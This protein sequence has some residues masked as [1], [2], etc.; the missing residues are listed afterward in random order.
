MDFHS[1]IP[2]LMDEGIIVVD[3]KGYIKVYNKMA[4]DIFGINPDEGT[5][6]TEGMIEDGDIVIIADNMLGADDGGMEP[7]DLRLIGIDPQGIKKGNAVVAIG[8]KGDI[9]GG[10]ISKYLPKGQGTDLYLEKT[11]LN[12]QLQT[13]I[14]VN[15]KRLR[16]KVNQNIYD[17]E[18]FWGA[19]HMVILDGNTMAVKFYQCKGYTARREPMKHI[20]LG[21]T[22]KGKGR[23][24]RA[25][26]TLDKHILELHPDSEVIRKL[27][28]VACGGS[29]GIKGMESL[30]NGVPVRCSVKAFD[31]DG[32][33]IGAMLE[34][35][36]ISEL[37]AILV[38]KERTLEHLK[39]LEDRLETEQ[40]EKQ[41]FSS[42]I[43]ESPAIKD[44]I[45]A[46]KK[47]AQTDSTVLLL[48]E[49]GTG[50]NLFAEAIHQASKRRNGPLVYINCASIP[51]TLL[52]SELFGHEKG[53]FTGAISKKLGKFELAHN[54]TIFLDEINEI[55]LSLQAKLLHVIQSRTFTRV[56]GIEP[57]SVNIRI[58]ATSNKDLERLVVEGL[59]RGDLFYR[60]NVISIY[61]PPLRE[62]K[63][64]LS[65]LIGY[66]LRCLE[67]KTGNGSKKIS[68]EVYKIFFDY[69]WPGNIRELEN[70][71]ER[72]KVM[73]G[74]GILP[75]HLPK[76]MLKNLEQYSPKNLVDI[77]NIGPIKTIVEEVE[78]KAIEKALCVSGGN[79]KKAMRLL[80]M[81]KTNFYTKLKKF[82]ITK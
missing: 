52:E 73:S 69:N 1:K 55:P 64:D 78:K 9:T 59:F 13:Q 35:M 10:G 75:E 42:I 50:K 38:E 77:N 66:L 11:I 17:Y 65:L 67:E 24:G 41:A 4:K 15:N 29:K 30:I 22:F 20:L 58:I 49:S 12:T 61:I 8:K 53:S 18:F 23:H 70:V 6:H 26:E 33:R 44:V 72:A 82:K 32:E 71:L 81:G 57:I 68:P 5:G 3:S 79:R 27:L 16:I 76:Y 31:K 25:L 39:N 51:E 2:D 37:K 54:G 19:G 34:I 7:T 56:G 36:D 14:D 21:G 28:N 62:R 43:G 74:I 60:I 47:A 48:G 46:A 80:K 63:E 45:R 40:R